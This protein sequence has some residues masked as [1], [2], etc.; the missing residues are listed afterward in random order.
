[1]GQVEDEKYVVFKRKEWEDQIDDPE[2]IADAV[3]IRRQDIFACA[4]F[5]TYSN[6]ILSVIET[7]RELGAEP[8]EHLMGIADYFHEQALRAEKSGARKVPD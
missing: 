3:V 6:Q 5:H 1:M 7:M 2:P 8:P 4:A